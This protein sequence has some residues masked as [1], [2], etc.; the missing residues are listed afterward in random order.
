MV[1]SLGSEPNGHGFFLGG[2]EIYRKPPF[3]RALVP[4]AVKDYQVPVRGCDPPAGGVY[5]C[6]KAPAQGVEDVQ[7]IV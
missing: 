7:G 3:M 6:D 4:P 1:S 2:L 5:V